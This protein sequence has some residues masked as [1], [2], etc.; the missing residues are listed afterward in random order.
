MRQMFVKGVYVFI[1]FFF[2]LSVSAGVHAE[3]QK[4]DI[5]K[6]TVEE[7]VSVKGI[8]KS[9][10]VKVVDFIKKNKGI[11]DMDELLNV[12]G[13]GKKTLEEIKKKFEV[14]KNDA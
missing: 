1:A 7:L 2:L 9:K 6:A 10:A 3:E 14:K 13:V 4:A 12:K 8:G 11:K 5:N